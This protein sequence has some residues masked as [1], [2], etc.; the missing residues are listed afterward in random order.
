MTNSP[1]G[2]AVF[3][4][5]GL[6]L[7]VAHHVGDYWVQTD[8]QA[9][10][11]GGAGWTGRGACLRHVLTYVT[12]QAWFL[13]V[14]CAVAGL[15]EEVPYWAAWVAL[16]VSGV[17]HYWA[18]RRWTLEW[19]AWLLEPVAGKLSFYRL[20]AP[21]PLKLV[22]VPTD[23]RDLA[24]GPRPRWSPLDAPTLGT[25]A[26]ALDQSFHLLF[27]VFVPALILAASVS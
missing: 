2:A 10:H 13:A 20:G 11:K 25:G 17:T 8:Y 23:G 9:R 3:A 21:R 18:D 15:W 6:A 19:L 26:W 16:A 24:E 14:A 1:T 12:T 27:S 22:A 7:Y 4:V 5:A